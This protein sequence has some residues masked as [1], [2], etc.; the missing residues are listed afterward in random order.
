MLSGPVAVDK[1]TPK[2][3]WRK[4]IVFLKGSVSGRDQPRRGKNINQVPCASLVTL[5]TTQELSVCVARRGGY[6]SEVSPT[7]FRTARRADRL[8]DERRFPHERR[9]SFPL[10]L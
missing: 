10:F 2:S 7:V 9:F 8:H 4:E 1:K 6:K 3:A 5:L